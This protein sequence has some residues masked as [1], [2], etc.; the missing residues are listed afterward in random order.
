MIGIKCH[1]FTLVKLLFQALWNNG[2][3][4]VKLEFHTCE[5]TLTV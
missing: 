5:T 1:G 3:T 2:F 4:V